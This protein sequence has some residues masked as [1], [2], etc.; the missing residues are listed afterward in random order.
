M[1]QIAV[2]LA[3]FFF[4]IKFCYSQSSKCIAVPI[5]KESEKIDNLMDEVLNPKNAHRRD[6]QA[7]SDSCYWIYF[8]K[9]NDTNHF[10]FQIE[11][12]PKSVINVLINN[13]ISNLN[14]GY[15]QYKK[16]K[17]FVEPDPGLYDFFN[18]TSRTQT[19]DFI[20]KLE[21]TQPLG[22]S[23]YQDIWHYQYEGNRLSI[24]GPPRVM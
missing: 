14:V 13:T 5:L 23:Y 2:F 4:G 1:K 17:I 15:F 19:F 24:E 11:K 12:N 18:K 7:S 10:I 20:Y 16:Y 8:F 3:L 6:T 22:H 9:A 21:S